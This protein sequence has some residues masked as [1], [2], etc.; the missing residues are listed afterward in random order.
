MKAAGILLGW[1][2]ARWI[3]SELAFKSLPKTPAAVKV[4][5]CSSLMPEVT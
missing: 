3:R 2:N 5:W 4:V 1:P